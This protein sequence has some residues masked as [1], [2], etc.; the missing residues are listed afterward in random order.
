MR[1]LVN[2]KGLQA[3]EGSS[4]ASNFQPKKKDM[5]IKKQIMKKVLSDHLSNQDEQDLTP[6]KEPITHKTRRKILIKKPKP[7]PYQFQTVLM[8]GSGAVSFTNYQ[9]NSK[10][11]P[12]L[13]GQNIV[14]SRPKTS[15][16]KKDIENVK[17]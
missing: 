2:K 1:D 6:V 13:F 17:Q 8:P 7:S 14:P 11:N 9:L 4:A 3:Y 15:K 12:Y 5:I 16:R 10:S